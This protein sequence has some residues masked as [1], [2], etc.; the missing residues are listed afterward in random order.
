M[1]VIADILYFVAHFQLHKIYISWTIIA[2]GTFK[3]IW[4]SLWISL[5]SLLLLLL[6]LLLY[7]H[8]YTSTTTNATTASTTLLLIIMIVMIIMIIIIIIVFHNNNDD[9][10]GVTLLGKHIVHLDQRRCVTGQC[11]YTWNSKLHV[12]VILVFL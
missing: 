12:L 8:Y 4:L 5:L 6:L 9:D 10:I 11:H 2:T 1:F 3:F 7:D